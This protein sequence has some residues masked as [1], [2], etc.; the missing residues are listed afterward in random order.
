MPQ[1]V[2]HRAGD[3]FGGYLQGVVKDH[4]VREAGHLCN[5][6]A[7][8][9]GSLLANVQ[10]TNAFWRRIRGRTG[11]RGALA[12][13]KRRHR[14]LVV[15]AIEVGISAGATDGGAL[16]LAKRPRD[17]ADLNALHAGLLGMVVELGLNSP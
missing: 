2:S 15:H 5:D 16:A 11:E 7:A 8:A 9:I 1:R 17:I 3:A 14:P 4:Q 12:T 6:A 13:Y 10:P